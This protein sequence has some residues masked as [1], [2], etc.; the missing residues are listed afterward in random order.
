MYLT[1]PESVRNFKL[2]NISV[3]YGLD[4][5]LKKTS[6]ANNDVVAEF[7]I[8]N[9]LL[10]SNLNQQLPIQRFNRPLP[11]KFN[12]ASSN[13]FDN[14]N[15][16]SK[17]LISADSSKLIHTKQPIQSINTSSIDEFKT[18]S[19]EYYENRAREILNDPNL[20]NQFLNSPEFKDI[21]KKQQS[22]ISFDLDLSKIVSK[23]LKNNYFVD[24][25]LILE[26]V[27]LALSELDQ[28]YQFQNRINKQKYDT[29]YELEE[30]MK[31][32]L[33][34]EDNRR[35]RLEKFA[36]KIIQSK[37]R[38]SAIKETKNRIIEEKKELLK[39]KKERSEANNSKTN[40]R[41]DLPCIDLDS[42]IRYIFFHY[43]LNTILPAP[44][45][46]K[47]I[48]SFFHFKIFFNR[49][50][51]QKR[52]EIDL[53]YKKQIEDSHYIKNKKFEEAVVII[54]IIIIITLVI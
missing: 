39:L 43:K 49:L 21:L 34:Y 46:S 3:D 53:S 48:L 40:L 51:Q 38:V 20:K 7:S 44:P 52:N 12:E 19:F 10:N 5:L 30:N 27:T 36:D 1:S 50:V 47:F 35:E 15:Q 11:H 13:L 45:N 28:N 37:E 23:E 33:L 4:R 54:F 31:S 2:L 6:I 26:I 9:D 8:S 16:S 22:C 14:K 29:K 25:G 24:N 17:D 42:K 32:L 18:S 41:S